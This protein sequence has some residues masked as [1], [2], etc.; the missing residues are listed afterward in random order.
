MKYILKNNGI[1]FCILLS[2]MVGFFVGYDISNNFTELYISKF[3]YNSLIYLL[4]V[5]VIYGD[6]IIFKSLNGNSMLM[7]RKGHIYQLICMTKNEI[8]TN[9][10]MFFFLHIPIFLFNSIEF[11]KNSYLIILTFS[12]FIIVS[13]SL[14][15]VVKIV[16][17][18]VKN[19][20][21]SS[22]IILVLFSC[23]HIFSEELE[24][25][26]SFNQIFILA[27]VYKFYF[28]IAL[29]L[30]LFTIVLN[31]LFIFLSLKK[32]YCLGCDYCEEN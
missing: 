6:Y 29:L 22:V 10:L 18:I 1:A 9:S 15:S 11:I 16:D 31:L 20:A 5:I 17:I 28:I 26:F 13:A 19:R 32:D 25:F 12:N 21:K 3:S 30:L 24:I 4:L 8:I 27:F 14:I 7:R 2:V 23:F